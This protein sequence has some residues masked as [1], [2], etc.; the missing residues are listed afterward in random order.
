[1]IANGL[2]AHDTSLR[3]EL[4][5]LNKAVVKQKVEAYVNYLI[6]SVGHVVL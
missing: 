2:Q 4:Q 3:K 1:M 5:L 6:V